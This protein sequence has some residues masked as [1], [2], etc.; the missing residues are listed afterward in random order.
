M[1]VIGLGTSVV[2]RRKL[3]ICDYGKIVCALARKFCRVFTVPPDEIDR[4]RWFDDETKVP[5]EPT[6]VRHSVNRDPI[7][8]P[9]P[10]R[11]GIAQ[12]SHICNPSLV[13]GHL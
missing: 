3:G 1:A 11:E 4:T 10:N 6:C 7:M 9:C 13:P 12:G 8:L 2:D 5:R